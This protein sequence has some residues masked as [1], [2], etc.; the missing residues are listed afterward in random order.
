MV[1][2]SAGGYLF[3][4]A[5]KSAPGSNDQCNRIAEILNERKP[6]FLLLESSMA[7]TSKKVPELA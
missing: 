7:P 5:N 3:K 1:E 2:G 6:Q 4:R